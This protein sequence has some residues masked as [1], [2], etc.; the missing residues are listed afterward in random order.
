MGVR[1]YAGKCERNAEKGGGR[2]LCGGPVQHQQSGVDQ[3]HP[4]DCGGDEGPGDPRRIRG[5]GQVYDRLHHRRRD[6]RR[7]GQVAGHHRS[8]GAA[9]RPRYL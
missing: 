5:R 4:A 6:G 9:P 7:D 1:Q 2:P 3:I 8:G